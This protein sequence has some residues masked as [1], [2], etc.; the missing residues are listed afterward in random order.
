MVSVNPS[1]QTQKT[2]V[3]SMWHPVFR[4]H[5]RVL[6]T[7]WLCLIASPA[8]SGEVTSVAKLRPNDGEKYD[9]FGHSVDISGNYAV[10]AAP[11]LDA[12]YVF[13]RDGANWTRQAKLYAGWTWD[14]WDCRTTVGISG[15][16]IVV[17]AEHE[18]VL[19]EQR[20]AAYIYTRSGSKWSLQEQLL[21]DDGTHSDGF[22]CSVAISG[23]VV[24]IGAPGANAA[25]VFMYD[26]GTWIQQ[27]KLQANDGRRDFGQTVAIS[28][29]TIVIGNGRD[30][31]AYTFRS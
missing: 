20:G 19:G 9:E 13:I 5:C 12:A 10:V 11:G 18:N 1:K 14:T 29:Q 2:Q 21:A 15:D 17:G 24:V 28:G 23:D 22:G 31:D 8:V 4:V 27:A 25:Y 26:G 16:A 3:H 30:G 7:F 6:V